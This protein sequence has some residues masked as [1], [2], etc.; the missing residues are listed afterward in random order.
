MNLYLDH[1]DLVVLS[2]CETGVGKV[3]FGEGVCGLQRAFL[4]AGA[5][6][7]I[8]SLFKVS[9]NITKELMTIFMING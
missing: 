6:S 7:V 3:Q 5:N 1:T 4:I 2:A 9:D 8:M